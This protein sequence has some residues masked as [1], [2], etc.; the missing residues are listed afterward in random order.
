MAFSNREFFEVFVD[1][2]LSTCIARDPKGLYAKAL[3]GELPNFTGISAPFEA[4]ENPDL[5]LS[6]ENS[7]EELAEEVLTFFELAR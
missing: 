7:P 1:T 2:P 3:G 5:R 4:P 6:G